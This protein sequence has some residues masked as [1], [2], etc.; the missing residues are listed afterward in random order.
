MKGT[1]LLIK[2]MLAI[3]ILFNASFVFSQVLI[4]GT[5]TDAENGD[6][7]I[8]ANVSD[9]AT[10]SGTT[11]DTNGSFAMEVEKLPITLVVSYIGYVTKELLVE[12][13]ADIKLN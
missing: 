7:L 6:V 10:S 11:T 13:D 1:T 3:A 12:S 4:K 8:G 2:L 5:V 9:K